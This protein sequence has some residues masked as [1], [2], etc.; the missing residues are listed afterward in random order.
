MKGFIQY[1]LPILLWLALIFTVSL[2]SPAVNFN[3]LPFKL[4]K[5]AHL[6]EFGI[7]G[8]FLVRAFYFGLPD[9]DL[10]RA[11]LLTIGVAIFFAGTDELLQIYIPGRTASFY[12]FIF[13]VVGIAGSQILFWYYI[14]FRRIPE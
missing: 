7:L 10:K 12:D 13:D 9:S 11:L 8:L 5:L 14:I 4:D 6:I 3:R 1:Y 2:I